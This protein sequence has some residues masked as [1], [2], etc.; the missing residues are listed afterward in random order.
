MIKKTYY[1]YIYI[2]IYISTIK[3]ALDVGRIFVF[4]WGSILKLILI[5]KLYKKGKNK[6]G[7]ID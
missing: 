4:Y 7:F 6:R 3:I 5:N 2:Y 1:I